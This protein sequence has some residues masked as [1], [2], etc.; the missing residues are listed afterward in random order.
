MDKNYIRKQLL[1]MFGM[2]HVD[3]WLMKF[4]DDHLFSPDYHRD[5]IKYIVDLD[6]SLGQIVPVE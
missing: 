6:L 4:P 5:F 1:I 3:A 2:V